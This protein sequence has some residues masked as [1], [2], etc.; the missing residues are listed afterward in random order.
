[1]MKT[2]VCFAFFSCMAFLLLGCAEYREKTAMSRFVERCDSL[3]ANGHYLSALEAIDHYTRAH[4]WNIDGLIGR[5]S[6]S[7]VNYCE[8]KLM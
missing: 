3:I 8:T 1:M 6:F 2:T 5:R 4:G 7:L